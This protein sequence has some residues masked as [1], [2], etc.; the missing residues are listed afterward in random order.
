MMTTHNPH[1]DEKRTSVGHKS[2]KT[3]AENGVELDFELG[4]E[5]ESVTVTE[6]K[7]RAEDTRSVEEMK[8]KDAEIE[9]LRTELADL[10]DKY[11]RNLADTQN[12]RRRAEQEMVRTRET[13]RAD[14]FRALLGVLDT[15]DHALQQDKANAPDSK[16][17]IEGL[18]LIYEQILEILAHEGLKPIKAVGEPFNPR[19]HEA[20]DIVECSDCDNN[21]IVGEIQK[22]YSLN[23]FVLRPSK[24]RINK[25][26][27]VSSMK[28]SK[29]SNGQKR[30]KE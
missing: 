26:E 2:D 17:S 20:C 29:Q 3:S 7:M 5:S 27:S 16:E 23:S 14:A 13:A 25:R 6:T 12:A 18:Q 10:K 30:E 28:S 24:V 22:G 8:A 11:I 21:V 19:F 1:D 15:F 9:R 4:S